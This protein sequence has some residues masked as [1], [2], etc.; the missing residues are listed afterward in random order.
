MHNLLFYA[1]V[2][3]FIPSFS[4]E[5]LLSFPQRPLENF[6]LFFKPFKLFSTFFTLYDCYY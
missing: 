1:G 3:S 6:F 2:S 4:V 5:K